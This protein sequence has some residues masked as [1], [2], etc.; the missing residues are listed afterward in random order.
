LFFLEKIKKHVL[1]YA[2]LLAWCLM[3]NHFHL[4]VYVNEVELPVAKDAQATTQGLSCISPSATQSRARTNTTNSKTQSFQHSIGVMLASYTRA[5]N[6]QNNWTGSLF[7]S[8]TKA[9]CLTQNDKAARA[10]YVDKGLTTINVQHPELQY[11]NVCFNY[12]NFNPVKDGLVKRNDEWEFS[13][14]PD[15]VGMRNGK[16]ISRERIAEFGLELIC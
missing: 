6:K 7:R 8:E 9:I 5:I 3:P 15:I 11:P 4:M 2:D 16:L 10:Y 13:S 14:Y 1:P 12:I